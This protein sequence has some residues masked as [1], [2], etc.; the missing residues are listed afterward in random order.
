VELR[1]V[2]LVLVVLGADTL[3][4]L[5]FPALLLLS[6]AAAVRNRLADRHRLVERGEIDVKGRGRMQTWLLEGRRA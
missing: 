1:W 5:A 2:G 3:L 6:V 4:R